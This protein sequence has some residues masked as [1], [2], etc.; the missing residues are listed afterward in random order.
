VNEAL[1]MDHGGE[2]EEDEEEEE[3][4]EERWARS[5]A[6]RARRSANCVAL[7]NGHS[8]KR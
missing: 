2:T 5:A 3:E 1:M 7:R 4:E 6:V 8:W